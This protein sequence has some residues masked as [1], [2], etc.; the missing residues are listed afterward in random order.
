MLEDTILFIRQSFPRHFEARVVA[1]I[2]GKYEILL[3]LKKKERA[4]EKVGRGREASSFSRQA[5]LG[6][7]LV[8]S[9]RLCFLVQVFEQ[10]I[11][12]S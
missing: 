6:R 9:Q 3:P 12:L 5:L 4:R 1:G 11:N 8:Q 10:A 2:I 7:I